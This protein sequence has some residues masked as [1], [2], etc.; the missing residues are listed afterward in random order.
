MT[1]AAHP[2]DGE[3]APLISNR[4]LTRLTVGIAVL[5]GLS[6]A[7]SAGGRVLGERIALSG[8]TESTEVF[9]ILVGQ[10]RVRLPANAIRFEEQRR[11]GIAERVDLY[12]TWPALEG[13]SN[14][15]RI[16]F[17]DVAHAENLIFLHLS[18][19]TMS[20]DMSGRLEPIYRHLFEGAPQPGPAGL[21][22]HRL[23]ANSGYG[24][25]VFFTAALPDGSDYAVRCMMPADEAQSTGADCQ[26]DIH[27][28][29]DLS[30][31]YRFSSRLLPQWQSMEARARAW[32]DERISG[33]S[34]TDKR[35]RT[36]Q[37]DNSS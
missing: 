14:A 6:V 15:E 30:V 34:G 12:L 5:A 36:A 24:D 3:H 11:S 25:E 23:K 9:D 19:S 4:L 35:R 1:A 20:K 26:R 18:Q 21:S 29:R 10:D 31:L 7:I 27:V 37:T 17:N 22:M 28:G 2:G 8:H 16:R 32:L 13:Y 33:Q